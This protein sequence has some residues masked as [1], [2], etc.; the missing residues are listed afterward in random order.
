MATVASTTAIL[1]SWN[2]DA[3]SSLQAQTTYN[4]TFTFKTSD[5]PLGLSAS[6]LAAK[7]TFV[8][9]AFGSRQIFIDAEL[10]PPASLSGGR[11]AV[12]QADVWKIT[13]EYVPQMRCQGKHHMNAEAIFTRGELGKVLGS[14]DI[15][16]A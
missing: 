15:N 4:R 1:S 14:V 2:L 7:T 8:K 16:E 9:A 11:D 6:T 3:S 12:G 10:T 5:L 13:P